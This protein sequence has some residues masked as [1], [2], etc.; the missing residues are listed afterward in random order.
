M[1]DE[2]EIINFFIFYL[3]ALILQIKSCE[4]EYISKKK[5]LLK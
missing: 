1:M 2:K 3:F 4:I 5:K